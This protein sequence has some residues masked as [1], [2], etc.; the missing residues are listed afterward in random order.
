MAQRTKRVL[1]S[2]WITLMVAGIVFGSFR[3]FRLSK[4]EASRLAENYIAEHY[5]WAHRATYSLKRGFGAWQVT[6][7]TP[8][9]VYPASILSIEVS[10]KGSVTAFM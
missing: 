8:D 5:E 9:D 3:F 4:T 2:I 10:D 7:E 6:V 1:V